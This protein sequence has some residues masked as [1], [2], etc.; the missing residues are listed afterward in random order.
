MNNNEYFSSV[1][2]IRQIE[3]DIEKLAQ[4]KKSLDARINDLKSE[5]DSI[6]DSIEMSMK[7]SGSYFTSLEDGTEI[8]IRNGIKSYEWASD[9]D[10][11]K[12]LKSMGKFESICSVE[13]V[14]NK[15]KIKPFLDDLSDC[16]GLPDF[17]A[18]K[19][20]KIMQI[21][22]S[23]SPSFEDKPKTASKVQQKKS[24]IDEFDSSELDGI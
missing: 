10:M 2:K 11:I 14:I 3:S 5:K 12:Y 8:S 23:S 18:V 4:E 13:T 6:R 24:N 21:R 15:K 1:Q 22:S 16:D 19:Q 20:D 9:D 17:V 7:E